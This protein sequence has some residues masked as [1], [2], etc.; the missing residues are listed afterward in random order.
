MPKQFEG[1][2]PLLTIAVERGGVLV[3][4]D[5]QPDAMLQ[6][7]VGEGHP[8]AH[9]EVA[10]IGDLWWRSW[11]G[12]FESAGVGP[13]SADAAAWTTRPRTSSTCRRR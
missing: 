3:D 8:I 11:L 4:A 2:S 7:L 6:I 13:L 12:E 10:A 1:D 5:D 9:A